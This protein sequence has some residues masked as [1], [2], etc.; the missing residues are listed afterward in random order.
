MYLIARYFVA[1]AGAEESRA[2]FDG[3]NH[4]AHCLLFFKSCFHREET[5][6]LPR[7]GHS[8]TSRLVMHGQPHHLVASADAHDDAAL[9]RVCPHGMAEAPR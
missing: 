6:A 4:L 9:V 2:P 5:Q 7:A 3:C 8:V 1:R